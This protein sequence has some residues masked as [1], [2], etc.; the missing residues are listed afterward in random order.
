[1]AFSVRHLS[2]YSTLM[3]SK[4]SSFH[5]ICNTGGMA[6]SFSILHNNFKVNILENLLGI[7][8]LYHVKYSN[9]KCLLMGRTI[10][11]VITRF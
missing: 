11:L 7:F 6:S 5:T 8:V 3:V 2:I 1:M 9:S 10:D 4:F